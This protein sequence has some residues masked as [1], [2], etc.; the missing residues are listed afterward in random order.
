[1]SFQDKAILC[2]DCGTTF[3]FSAEQ[4]EFLA[5]K[6]SIDIPK[7]CTRCRAA[8]K[9]KRYGDGDYSYRSRSWQQISRLNLHHL[10]GDPSSN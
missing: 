8:M 6:G 1:M 5:S 7:R 4:Q 3:I 9:M 10:L 2:S